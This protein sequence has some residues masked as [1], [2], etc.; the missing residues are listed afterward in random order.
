MSTPISQGNA[1]VYVNLSDNSS[2]SNKGTILDLSGISGKSNKGDGILVAGVSWGGLSTSGWVTDG[3]VDSREGNAKIARGSKA[4]K[5]N[6]IDISIVSGSKSEK[7]YSLNVDRVSSKSNKGYGLNIDRVSSKRNISG[8]SKKS[9]NNTYIKV[10]G[11]SS[12]SNKANLVVNSVSNAWRSDGFVETLAPTTWS[13]DVFEPIPAPANDWMDDG[14]DD[15]KYLAATNTATSTNIIYY[16]IGSGKSKKGAVYGVSSSKSDKGYGLNV[17]RVRSNSGYGYN[18]KAAGVSSKSEKQISTNISVSG[19]SS[20]HV[21][22]DSSKANKR[23]PAQS[24]KAIEFPTM[25]AGR[26]DGDPVTVDVTTD[27][28]EI[29]GGYPEVCVKVC[30]YIKS[31]FEGG[32]LID[33]TAETTEE[34]CD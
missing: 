12:I 26:G 18:V 13:S 23:I 25:Y 19:K 2:K 16:Y 5:G 15:Q 10:N 28:R 20:F 3:W 21:S 6:H 14:W 17:H 34:E 29:T 32:K 11:G 8:K 33:E 24:V 22:R 4:S 30:T 9:V 1:L 7:G 31:S 27:C